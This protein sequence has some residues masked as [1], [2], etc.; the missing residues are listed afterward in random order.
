MVEPEN[1][2]SRKTDHIQLA[3]EAQATNLDDRF[4]Y[5]PMLNAHP[6]A[7][8]IPPLQLAGKT[9]KAPLWI[10]SMTGGAQL[11]G[12]IN[13][14][15]ALA[16]REFGL[17]MGLGSCRPL[18]GSDESLPDFAIRKHIGDQPLFANLGIA[19]IE[20]ML[21]L[22]KVKQISTL[23]ERLEA[24]GLIV[25]VNPLQEWLQPEGDRIAMSPLD[26]ITH[27]LDEVGFPVMVKEVGQGFG[28]K[29]M[30]ALSALPLEAIEFAA[31]GGTNFALLENLR[32]DAFHQDMYEPVTHIGHSPHEMVKMATALCN[33]SENVIKTRAYIVSGG[34]RNFL[35]GYY[36]LRGIPWKTMYAQASAFLK[37]AMLGEKEV[38]EFTAAQIKGLELA[39]TF[40]TLKK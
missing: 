34:V 36:Y 21:A 40:L 8:C 5:E 17:G 25:H 3:F 16:C 10:S 12:T 30:E 11:A 26:T 35:D 28:P 33:R 13:R 23:V 27:L 9:L 20:E 19:Q 4:N 6:V 2:N 14:N 37:Y 18:L 22:G 31:Q 39:Y 7:G 32:S 15:L 38:M 29:S 24:D 1:L